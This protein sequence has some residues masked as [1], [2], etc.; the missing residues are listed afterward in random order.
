MGVSLQGQAVR[1]SDSGQASGRPTLKIQTVQPGDQP[2]L[3]TLDQRPQDVPDIND[4]GVLPRC[5]IDD[6][7]AEDVVRRQFLG[8]RRRPWVYSESCLLDPMAVLKGPC[9]YVLRIPSK[10]SPWHTPPLY[11]LTLSAWPTV[12]C[13]VN[14]T[15][16]GGF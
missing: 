5:R 9:I 14:C 2:G 16:C 6:G 3:L 4:A 11:L 7:C 13:V 15:R 1:G 10:A 8:G 12:V